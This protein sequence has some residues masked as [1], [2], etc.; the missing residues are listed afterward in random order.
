MGSDRTLLF[1][2]ADFTS[3]LQYPSLTSNSGVMQIFW[4]GY[5]LLGGTL[6]LLMTTFHKDLIERS[7]GHE[8]I[9][10]SISYLRW[11]AAALILGDW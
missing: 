4:I 9:I 3:S 10:E 11:G 2:R 1:D 8:V 6:F 7:A 5:A